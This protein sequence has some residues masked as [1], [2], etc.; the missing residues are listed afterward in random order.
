MKKMITKNYK[1]IFSFLAAV[2]IGLFMVSCDQE[3]NTGFATLNPTSPT[4]SVAT[5][6]SSATFIENDQVYTFTATL[7]ATQLV[8]VKLFI[9]QI[10]GD[11]TPGSDYTVDGTIVIPAGALSATGEIKVLADELIEET[12]TVTIQVGD[13]QTANASTATATMEFTILNYTASDVAIDLSWAITQTTTN[14]S[15]VEVDPTDFADL[16]LLLTESADNS[17]VW[18]DA[19]G[20]GFETLVVNSDTPD[21]TYYVVADFYDVNDD[22]DRDLDLSVSFYQA[23]VITDMTFNYGAALNSMSNCESVSFVMAQIVKVG[24]V[25]TVTPVG[26]F[27]RPVDLENYEGDYWYGPDSWDYDTQ[28]VTWLDEDTFMMNGVGF[29]WMEDAWG[30]PIIT[31]HPFIVDVD[32]STGNFVVE[33]QLYLE[34]SYDG[35]VQPPYFIL[36]SGYIDD[37]TGYLVF[38]YSYEQPGFDWGFDGTAWGPAFQERVILEE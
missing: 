10:G 12:E 16:R 27:K 9:S 7:S 38:N 32:W 1:S 18:D 31:S 20:S 2:T 34:T 13:N 8:D 29:E 33:E 22:L 14:Q 26:E 35:E 28:V 36:G 25:Y 21:G 24:E 23:G 11:A 30:E 15:G 19:D 3:E 4:L 37:C 6:V 5:E 17:Q